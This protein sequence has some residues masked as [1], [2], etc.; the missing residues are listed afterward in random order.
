MNEAKPEF[1]RVLQLALAL[2]AG[3]QRQLA[4]VM[5]RVTGDRT[6][7][8][9]V[10]PAETPAFA[11]EG[12]PVSAEEW[13]TSIA[14]DSPWNRLQM[15]EGVLY[16]MPDNDPERQ[17]LIAARRSL[18]DENPPLSVRRAVYTAASQ[19]PIGV[20]LGGCGLVLA[21]LGLGRAVLHFVF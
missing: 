6:A 17:V 3:D 10:G 13:L 14:G 4:D 7:G 12:P 21:I 20:V 1:S 15:I 9:A 2:P 18:L 8:D 5:A 19:H 11:Q 16:E